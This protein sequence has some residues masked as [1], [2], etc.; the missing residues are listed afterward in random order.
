MGRF[1]CQFAGTGE[2]CFESHQEKVAAVRDSRVTIEFVDGM[3]KSI[4]PYT[5][6]DYVE[7]EPT[8]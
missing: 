6:D 8:R 5:T 7:E 2:C 1:S 3:S 4:V